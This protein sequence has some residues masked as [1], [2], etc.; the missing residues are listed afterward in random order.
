MI[1]SS[2]YFTINTSDFQVVPPLGMSEWAIAFYH[3]QATQLISFTYWKWCYIEIYELK[4][5]A[6]IRFY[7]LQVAN[8]N[9]QFN[10]TRLGSSDKQQSKISALLSRQ[11]EDTWGK[12]VRWDGVHRM[13]KKFNYGRKCFRTFHHFVVIK[14]YAEQKSWIGIIVIRNYEWWID[15]FL[16]LLVLYRGRCANLW[17]R[18][19]CSPSVEFSKDRLFKAFD[20][21]YP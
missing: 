5:S 12:Q 13:Y 21:P 3:L 6:N 8:R 16:Q 1:I 18:L 20:T 2:L 14:I 10:L 9:L 15:H 4:W 11:I 19:R 7:E 17:G